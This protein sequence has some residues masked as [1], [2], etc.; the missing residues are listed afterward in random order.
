MSMRAPRGPLLAALS[1]SAFGAALAGAD[2]TVAA[3]DPLLKPS[4]S[5]VR[6]SDA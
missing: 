1:F 4:R 6:F 3:Q 5:A 2:L